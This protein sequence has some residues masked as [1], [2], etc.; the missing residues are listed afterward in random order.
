M[1]DENED[2]DLGDIE[3]LKPSFGERLRARFTG[4]ESEDGGREQASRGPLHAAIAGAAG[5]ALAT[6][7]PTGLMAI[8]GSVEDFEGEADD[9]AAR[10]VAEAEEASDVRRIVREVLDDH[11][12]AEERPEV[13]EIGDSIWSAFDAARTEADQ[14]P[15]DD[16]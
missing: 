14:A 5:E 3:E 1:T 8:G 12:G 11:H 9:I 10:T 2:V 16:A 7:D 4:D 6:H 15:G 13:T